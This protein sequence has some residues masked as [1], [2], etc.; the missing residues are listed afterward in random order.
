VSIEV[1]LLNL[2][3]ELVSEGIIDK[4]DQNNSGGADAHGKN[5]ELVEAVSERVRAYINKNGQPF[6]VENSNNRVTIHPI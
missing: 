3:K 4:Y 1:N 2:L 5:G 6:V